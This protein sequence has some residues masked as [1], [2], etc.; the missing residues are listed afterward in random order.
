MALLRRMWERVM[1][2]CGGAEGIRYYYLYQVW[3]LSFSL[4]A[5]CMTTHWSLNDM[6]NMVFDLTC[7]F[8]IS[9]LM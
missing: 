3:A 6:G 2:V 1:G 9:L 4:A 7:A 5:F 8:L